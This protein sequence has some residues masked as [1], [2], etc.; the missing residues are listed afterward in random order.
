MRERKIIFIVITLLLNNICVAFRCTLIRSVLFGPL[1]SN[2]VHLARLVHPIHFDSFSQFWSI[3]I[4]L[5]Y[6]VHLQNALGNEICVG[7]E[8]AVHWQLCHIFS[9]ILIDSWELHFSYVIEVFYFILFYFNMNL[10]ISTSPL[11]HLRR[12]EDELF[13]KS[14][15]N[16]FQPYIIFFTKYLVLYS[17]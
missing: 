4:Y 1:Q 8:V 9:V 10:L 3:S 17:N 6:S 14:I 12:I 11:G 13:I 7:R 2:M 5:V 16:K 15:R